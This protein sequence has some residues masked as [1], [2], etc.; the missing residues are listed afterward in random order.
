MEFKDLLKW[1]YAI[2]HHLL[3]DSNSLLKDHTVY[4]ELYDPLKLYYLLDMEGPD[5]ECAKLSQCLIFEVLFW[6]K[7]FVF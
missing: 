2:F 7:C 4:L 1:C 5:N 6:F 3:G